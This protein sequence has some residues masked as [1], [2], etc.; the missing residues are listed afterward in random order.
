MLQEHIASG[1]RVEAFDME[2]LADGQWRSAASSTVI[3]H[4]RLVRFADAT[5]VGIRIRLAEFRVRP[6]LAGLGLYLAPAVI[7]GL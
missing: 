3:G 1:Q 4:K 2:V 5:V 7:H 6:T